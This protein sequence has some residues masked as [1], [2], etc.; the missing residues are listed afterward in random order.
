MCC[1]SAARFNIASAVCSSASLAQWTSLAG[2]LPERRNLDPV[3]AR[4]RAEPAARVLRDVDVDA[5]TLRAL[6]GAEALRLAL[7]DHLSQARCTNRGP[8]RN[9]RRFVRV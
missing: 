2:A 6:A 5:S 1:R 3:L 8:H 9:Q 7:A 4:Q